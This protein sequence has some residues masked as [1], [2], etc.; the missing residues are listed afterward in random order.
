MPSPR[1]SRTRGIG[2]CLLALAAQPIALGL[3]LNPLRWAN[4]QKITTGMLTNNVPPAS[5]ILE[6]TQMADAR[7]LS[8]YPRPRKVIMTSVQLGDEAL[9]RVAAERNAVANFECRPWLGATALVDVAGG[10][11]CVISHNFM[12]ASASHPAEAVTVAMSALKP[13]GRFVWIEP[14]GEGAISERVSA[15]WRAAFPKAEI[16]TDS[17]DGLELGVA[18]KPMP[19]E[20]V[21]KADGKPKG[22]SRRGS[23]GFGTD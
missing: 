18:V 14:D 11:N 15:L 21:R 5:A 3:E 8:L 23:K 2:A 6:L 17:E 22:A 10:I 19:R 1:P 9:L 12:H 7:S 13:G 4:Q 20:T 16:F